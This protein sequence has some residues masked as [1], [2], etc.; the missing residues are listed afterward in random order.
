MISRKTSGGRERVK[1]EVTVVA[2]RTTITEWEWSDRAE[3]NEYVFG[4][5]RAL[6]WWEALL[7][8]KILAGFR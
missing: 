1:V 4:H 6:R 7:W 3:N 2:V 5:V 8:P